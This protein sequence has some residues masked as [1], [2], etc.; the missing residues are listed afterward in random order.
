MAF[1][2]D[3]DLSLAI[4]I[5]GPD[6]VEIIHRGVEPTTLYLRRLTTRSAW[7]GWKQTVTGL[8]AEKPVI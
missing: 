2:Q 4:E 5:Q 8:V 1:A 3:L 7:L 6:V